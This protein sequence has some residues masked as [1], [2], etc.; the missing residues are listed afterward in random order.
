MLKLTKKV[1]YG[2]MAIAYIAWNHG[3]RVVNTKEIAEAYSIPLE[4][5]AKI[6]Q[7]MVK[8]GLITSLSGPKGGY[9]LST[10]PSDITVARIIEAVEGNINILNC[11][12]EE[13]SRCYQ[14]DRC[15]IRTPMQRLEHRIVD[16]LNKTT[17]EELIERF[18]LRPLTL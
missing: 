12:E 6:L 2:L 4:L 7:R 10:S 1:D 11:S 14:F 17:L 15:S 5:L 3:E 18:E 13:S 16:M 9:S 8:G